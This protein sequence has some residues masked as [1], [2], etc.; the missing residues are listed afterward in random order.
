MYRLLLWFR[1]SENLLWVKPAIGSLLAILFALFA[2]VGN[3]YDLP[4]GFPGIDRETL[5]G[6]LTVI[7]SSMLAVTT[8]SLS[9]MVAAF[10]SASTQAT[11][12]ATELVVGDEHS[13]TAIASFISAF[14]YSIIAKSALGVSYYG[15]T[16]RFLLFLSTVAVLMYLIYTL[17]RWVKTMSLLGRMGNTINKIELATTTA[18]QTYRD[19]PTMGAML[20]S[21]EK[22]NGTAVM[23]QQVAYVRHIDI[24]ALQALAVELDGSIHIRVR[25]GSLVHPGTVLLVIETSSDVDHELARKSLV[26][27]RWRSFDQDPRFGMI[28]LS[29]VAQRALSPAV[30]DPGTAIA[31]MNAMTRILVEARPDQKAEV[32]PEHDR[33]SL[34][35]I[36]EGDF[37]QQGFNPIARDG[38]A[39]FE[40]IVRMQKLLS[41]IAEQGVLSLK[42]PAHHQA[43]SAAERAWQALAL[44]AEKHSVTELFASLHGHAVNTTADA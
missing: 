3:Q 37:I 28:V 41:T 40:V 31:V 38:A 25:P 22:V 5:D 8:F 35:E 16:G 30:N 32:L 24:E 17:I 7:A 23:C 33:L 1:D 43:A 4:K 39:N 11:P 9:I 18:M 42:A 36:D 2:A 27:G 44:D 6:L 14:I 10:A 26:L 12:R 15:E 34:I 13:H 20:P 21:P 19:R 29:E